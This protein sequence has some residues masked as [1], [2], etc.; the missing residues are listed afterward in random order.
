G[1]SITLD[2]S[3]K[4]M[5]SG[6]I[7]GDDSGD[8]SAD[9]DLYASSASL[10]FFSVAG[11]PADMTLG[12]YKVLIYSDAAG[13]GNRVA[14]YWLASNA[15]RNPA[16]VSSERNLTP[17]VYLRDAADFTGIFTRATGASNAGTNTPVG[18]YVQFDSRTEDA[19][20]VRA[21]EHLISAPI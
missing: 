8:G 9:T 3:D 17:R 4:R 2:T 18:N 7:E 12:G 11:L 13:T 15:D 16:N 20:T 6:F 14:S 21:E 5:M 1:T 19:F 10:P